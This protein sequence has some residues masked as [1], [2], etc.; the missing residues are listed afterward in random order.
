MSLEEF[1]NAFYDDT[2]PF[3][4]SQII[5]DEGDEIISTT[6]WDDP[7]N[8]EKEWVQAIWERQATAYRTYDAKLH[9]DDNPFSDHCWSLKNI[10]LLEKTDTKL[11]LGE[12]IETHGVMYSDRF[13][14]LAKWDIFTPDPRSQQV[15]LRHSYR[16]NWLNKPFAV[17]RLIEP[18]A[19]N[20][21][22]KSLDTLPGWYKSHKEEYLLGLETGV[23]DLP[24][25][26]PY[27]EIAEG[28]GADKPIDGNF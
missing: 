8:S 16:I 3:Y 10:L 24:E 22:N 14:M 1:W 19:F 28:E 7:H 2:A 12:V 18:V 6:K 20:K 9:V 25:E 21:M 13:R 23:Y 26:P 15:V 5:I 11:V 17:W 27:W 4:V